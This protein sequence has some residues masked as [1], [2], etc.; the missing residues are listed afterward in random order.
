MALKKYTFPYGRGFQTVM[1]P[2]ERISDVLEGMPTKACNIKEATISCMR[3]PIGSL[4][5]S[6]KVKPGDK[7][8]LVTADI[9]RAWNHV[10]DFMIHIVNE[11]NAAGI[12][13]EDIYIVF[14]QGTHRAHTEEENIECV[15]EEVAKRIRMYQHDC[16]DKDKLT[17]M[18]MTSRGTEVFIDTRVAAADKVI[19]I[20]AVS[21][22]DMAGFGGGRKLIL[23]GVA[24]WDTIQQ[25]HCHALGDEIGS[26]LN[27]DSRVLKIEGNPVSEDMQEGCDMVAPCFLIHS[28]IN[29]DGEVSGMVGGDP[30]K[31]WR[32]GTE[33]IY[34]MQKVPMKQKTDVTIVSAGGYPKDTNLYQGTKC[35]TSAEMATK[36]GGI[37]I[38]LMEAEDVYEPPAYLDSFKYPDTASMEKALRAC[39]TIPFFVAFCNLQTALTHTVYFVTRKENFDLIREKTHQ[40]PVA[41]LEEAWALA[42]KQLEKEGKTDYTVNLIPH[43][44]AVVPYLK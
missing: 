12:P 44:S 15:G 27:P 2:E 30:Y 34:R 25:N 32:K 17:Y 7:V 14:A 40:I 21:T 37:I 43:G 4:P 42:Q 5:L 24:G 33:E 8:C 1:L 31:A 16:R 28:L 39:F 41:T 29:A 9:T 35:Y 18:G 23:P 10:R 36:K 13:D 11:L 20:N 6:E 3:R 19:L 26:G 38:T 22:H